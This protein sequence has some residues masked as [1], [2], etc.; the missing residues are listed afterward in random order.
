[1]AKI[2]HDLLKCKSSIKTCTASLFGKT[3]TETITTLLFC[4]VQLFVGSFNQ[5]GPI[6]FKAHMGG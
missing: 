6:V 5:I 2:N 3:G 4:P 1:M